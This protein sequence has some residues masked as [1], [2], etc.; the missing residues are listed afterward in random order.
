M[1]CYRLSVINIFR[2]NIICNMC[3]DITYNVYNFQIT[4]YSLIGGLFVKKMN[5]VINHI[6]NSIKSI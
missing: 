1:E 3:I 4:M 2:G 5:D 6:T